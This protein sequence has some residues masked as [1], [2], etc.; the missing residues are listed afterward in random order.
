VKKNIERWDAKEKTI[1]KI[2]A[3]PNP[4]KNYLV[5][6]KHLAKKKNNFLSVQRI[7]KK[8]EL[9]PGLK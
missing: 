4:K 8:G 9:T 7:H 6:K 2:M 3:P 5:A 1:W